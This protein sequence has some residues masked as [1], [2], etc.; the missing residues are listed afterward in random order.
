MTSIGLRPAV[1]FFS[2]TGLNT[3]ASISAQKLSNGTT[4][5]IIF[6]GSPFATIAGCKATAWPFDVT[7]ALA[8]V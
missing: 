1:L 8:H 3:A 5:V 2:V 6:C 4:R 7:G